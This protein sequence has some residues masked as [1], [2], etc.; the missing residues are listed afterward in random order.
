[1]AENEELKEYRERLGALEK[2]RDTWVDHW[3]EI[4]D[5][6]LP[7]KGEYLTKGAI[8]NQGKKKHSKIVDGTASRA[9]RVL[10]AGM[11]GGLTSPARPWFRLKL[12]DED[13]MEFGPVRAWVHTVQQK[14][15][16]VFNMSNFYTGIHSIY[17]E[18][19]GFG[20]GCILA[21]PN[22]KK[23]VHFKI[24]TAG[25]YCL[26]LN[27]DRSVDTVF[28]RFFATARQLRDQFGYDNLSK[29]TQQLIDNKTPDDW[30]E[31]VHAV[32]PNESRD[33]RKADNRN[34]PFS[35]V[36]FEYNSNQTDNEFLSKGGY[37][38]FPYMAPRWD[39][40][41][42][43]IYGRSPGMD[44]LA[45]VKMLQ[46]MSRSR[47]VAMH[48]TLDPPMRVPAGYH[49]KLIQLPGGINM[50]DVNDDKAVSKLYDFN[51]D[52]P[53]TSMGIEDIRLQIREGLFNDLFL[54]LID[55]PIQKTATEIA[56][57][58]EEKLL[59]LGPVIERQFFELLDPLIDR[60]FGIMSRFGMLPPPPKEIQGMDIDVEY[61]SLLAQAQKLVGTQSINAF[62]GFVS[63][64][65]AVKA[66]APSEVWDKLDS[67]EAIDQYADM[68][69]VP[70]NI[71]RTD[72]HVEAIRKQRA[73]E[74]A[75]MKQEQEQMAAIQGAKELSQAQ[76]GEGQ[77]ALSD[78]R[79]TLEGQAA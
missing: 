9:L 16:D 50:I 36:Y 66:N 7:R 61:I 48:K 47:L 20:T 78:L 2:E 59:M 3:Q 44:V 41:G 30:V 69:G 1:M 67:D 79:N 10:A 49:K 68:T 13:L 74:A 56:A 32:Q 14:M 55:T 39:V 11:Q 35:S 17:G 70:V 24:M 23:V 54:M 31:A 22:F 26:A 63:N 40:T 76:T 12:S 65:A 72:D 28:R 18:L 8:P 57:K 29:P 25:E 71:V 6:I 15:Y 38:E 19:G 27:Q 52:I 34:M 46:E 5:Y 33:D 58:Q 51:F 43:E 77:N 37:P 53:S 21:L 45:D 64:L 75:R 4:T 73:D 42:S 60:V 62:V